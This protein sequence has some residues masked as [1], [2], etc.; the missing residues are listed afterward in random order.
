M[1][2]STTSIRTRSVSNVTKAAL[3]MTAAAVCFALMNVLVR[4][5]S[6][7]VPTMEVVFFRNM[8]AL[9]AMTPWLATAGLGGLRTRQIKLHITRAIVGVVAMIVWFAALVHVPLADAVALNFTLPLFIVLGAALLLGEGVGP[10]RWIATAVGFSGML[11]ILRPGF[12]DIS[13]YSALPVLAAIFMAASM[14]LLKRISAH[15]RAGTAV[16]MMNLLMTPLSLV[17]ALF[18]WQWPALNDYGVMAL[19]GISAMAAHL[20]LARAFIHADASV[21]SLFDYTRLPFVALFAWI[22]FGETAEIWTWLGAAII[23]GSSVYIARREAAEEK[24]ARLT[25]LTRPAGDV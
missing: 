20:F 23:I 18:V 13:V 9:L 15:D 6:K 22:L 24:K 16:T 2:T 11:V 3:Y 12:T 8:F 25:E 7:N 14:L 17:L 4:I 19:L 1:D 5:A 10:R 21:V